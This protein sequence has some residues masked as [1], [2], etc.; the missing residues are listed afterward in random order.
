MYGAPSS[1]F[2][3]PRMRMRCFRC[4][5]SG[6]VGRAWPVAQVRPTSTAGRARTPSLTYSRADR[7]ASSCSCRAASVLQLLR[8][9]VAGRWAP[10]GVP[11]TRRTGTVSSS[12]AS[13]RSTSSSAARATRAR[14]RVAQGFDGLSCRCPCPPSGP[15]ADGRGARLRAA[16]M[17]QR[18]AAARRRAASRAL[19]TRPCDCALLRS[20]LS[21]V[22]ALCHVIRRAGPRPSG[23]RPGGQVGYVAC[24]F[25]HI[26][27][28]LRTDW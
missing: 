28:T 7:T 2:S 1:L 20:V 9:S 6:R 4:R 16:R 25:S 24:L 8:R 3:S 17:P 15:R 21:C 22:G 23:S 18:E 5:L 12:A 14:D 11:M 19:R 27:R 10:L 26:T 13:A